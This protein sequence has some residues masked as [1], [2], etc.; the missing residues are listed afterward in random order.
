M[1]DWER[2]VGREGERT[3]TS[4]GRHRREGREEREEQKDSKKGWGNWMGREGQW[5]EGAGR[6]EGGQS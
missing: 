4:K 5:E 6:E 1:G 3:E 2:G